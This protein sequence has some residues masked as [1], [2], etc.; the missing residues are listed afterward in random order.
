MNENKFLLE[1]E[2]T[3][4]Y[5]DFYELTMAQGYF[6][7]GMHSYRSTFDYFF[8]KNPFA[9]GY[10]IFAG[11]A[12]FLDALEKFR[13][14]DETLGYL[15]ELG[16]RNEF[17]DYLE[18]FHF[19]GN[20]YSVREG[21]VV[22]PNE[23]VL[24]IE[25]SL[26][27]AQLIETLILNILNFESLIATKTSRIKFAAD[28]KMVIDFGMRRAQGYASL[29]ASRAAIIGGC[30]STS[31]VAA[32]KVYNLIPSGTMGHSWVQSFSDELTAFRRFVE[33]YSEKAILLVD[34][35]NTL[36]SGLPNAIVV[37]K[38]L[39]REGKRLFGIR[40]DSGD[41]AFLS[42]KAREMLD[43]SGLDYVKI[44]VSNQLDEYLIKS[45]LEQRARIDAFGVG[46]NLVIGKPD[47]ALDGVYKLSQLEDIPKIKIS[48]NVEKT[49]LPGIKNVFRFFN[50]ENKFFGDAIVLEGEEP[51][52]EFYH[53]LFPERKK[54]VK[55]L[56]NE[57]M[58]KLTV[59]RG[60]R[61]DNRRDVYEIAKFT[62]ERLNLLDDTH[63]RFQYPHI[64]KVGISKALL[65]L[66]KRLKNQYENIQGRIE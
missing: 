55:N 59:E 42:K 20:I 62:E 37:A 41:L 56:R 31:N 18:S 61:I 19:T 34:T 13:F 10:T 24:R 43:S 3:G 17:I 45:L 53:P 36:E 57:V 51:P 49:T 64:Y 35:F 40:L 44:A 14:P 52:E 25:A 9:G 50:G 22:F 12:D 32:A 16:F 26:A 8:R 58:L 2:L 46:T 7:S 47:A 30:A 21:E 63:K 39:E 33:I 60:R 27:E 28:G 11:L 4:I 29:L 23:P 65:E 5:T 48:E 66:K 15:K 6:L 54:V 38:E 1:E